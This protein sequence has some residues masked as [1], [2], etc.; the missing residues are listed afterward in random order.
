MYR[1]LVGV[2]IGIYIEQTYRIPNLYT[3]FLEFNKYLKEREKK[4]GNN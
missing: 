4:D 3:K 2:M 1:L